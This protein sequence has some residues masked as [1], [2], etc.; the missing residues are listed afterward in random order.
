M[1]LAANKNA[2]R[3]KLNG[4]KAACRD[5]VGPMAMCQHKMPIFAQ[6]RARAKCLHPKALQYQFL[7]QEMPRMVYGGCYCHLWFLLFPFRLA[8]TL[9]ALA[10]LIVVYIY[11]YIRAKATRPQSN[12]CWHAGPC[13][14]S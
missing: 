5:W 10:P 8:R 4:C 7:M 2:T 11:T 14:R 13:L 1:R 6:V 9:V 3:A 12:G